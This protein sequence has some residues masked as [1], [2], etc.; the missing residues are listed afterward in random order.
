MSRLME[1]LVNAST[2]LGPWHREHQ[3]AL[4]DIVAEVWWC[5]D[6]VCD[7]TQAQITA[8]YANVKAGGNWIVPRV[9]WTG[10]FFPEGQSGAEAE[11]DAMRVEVE[12]TEPEMASRI[13]WPVP[14]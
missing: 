14:V 7:C 11:L 8:R 9:L 2:N 1:A 4:R 10:T 6:E 13:T 3:G 5:G 12:A